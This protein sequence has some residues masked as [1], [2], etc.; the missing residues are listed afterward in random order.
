M[1]NVLAKNP[2]QV[3]LTVSIRSLFPARLIY[4]GRVSGKSYEWAEAGRVV[5]VLSED[6]PDLLSKRL[7]SGGCCGASNEP[8]R[9]FE[10]L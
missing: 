3:T 1:D 10:Q 6:A 9:P 4:T 5:E 8:N 2:P 7:G